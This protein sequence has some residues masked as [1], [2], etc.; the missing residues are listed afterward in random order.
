MYYLMN[1]IIYKYLSGEFIITEDIP[2]ECYVSTNGN[3]I[4]FQHDFI[5]NLSILLYKF[6][7]NYKINL[8]Y[9]DI[10]GSKY[11]KYNTISIEF[12]YNCY[13]RDIGFSFIDTNIELIKIYHDFDDYTGTYDNSEYIKYNKNSIKLTCC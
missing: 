10:N 2:N 3:Y 1:I 8:K 12:Y 4:I 6:N 5:T 11:Q 13:K 9:I 7:K